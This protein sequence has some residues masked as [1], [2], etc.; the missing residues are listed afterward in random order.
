[1]RKELIAHFAIA[2]KEIYE[3][4][5]RSIYD[6]ALAAGQPPPIKKLRL[7]SS[8]AKPV[9]PKKPGVVDTP[10]TDFAQS[11]AADVINITA[12]VH[13]RDEDIKGYEVPQP[14]NFG[15]GPVGNDDDDEDEVD[16][17][18]VEGGINPANKIYFLSR[19]RCSS[20]PLPKTTSTG[21]SAL[22]EFITWSDS[23]K[24]TDDCPLC[25]K[26]LFRKTEQHDV[27]RIH[28]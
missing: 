24:V 12:V 10:Y 21:F 14:F 28:D 18:G 25:R 3:A 17:D 5:E 23:K 7:A 26:V 27:R 2:L 22:P 1:M 4:Y 6:Q 13:M 8:N 15:S 9:T 19:T 20:C 11:R 16:G